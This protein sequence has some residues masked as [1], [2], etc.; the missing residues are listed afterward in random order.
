MTKAAKKLADYF[1]FANNWVFEQILR[2]NFRRN[3]RSI[4]MLHSLVN[5]MREVNRQKDIV[6]DQ[7][8]GHIVDCETKLT[9][10]KKTVEC[11]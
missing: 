9:Y 3:T 2:F 4:A 10:L 1:A 5:N 11:A 6:M 7:L 8:D